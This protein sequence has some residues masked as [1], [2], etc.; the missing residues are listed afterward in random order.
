MKIQSIT[1]TLSVSLKGEFK[2]HLPPVTFSVTLRLD[3]D[4]KEGKSQLSESVWSLSMDMCA[5]MF[6]C[7][8]MVRYCE[9]EKLRCG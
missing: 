6:C 7:Y 1:S 2:P 8:S 5:L 3:A 4:F 9:S